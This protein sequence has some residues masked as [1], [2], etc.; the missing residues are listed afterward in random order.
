[1]GDGGTKVNEAKID[2][3][4]IKEEWLLGNAVLAFFGALLMAQAWQPSDIPNEILNLV[5]PTLPQLVVLAMVAVL[6][7][8][9]IIFALGSAI[10][11]IRSW[12]ITQATS[13]SHFL[14]WL[15]WFVFLISLLS[16]LSEIATDQW[17]AEVLELGGVAFLLFLAFR[18]IVRPLINPAKWLVHLLFKVLRWAWERIVALRRKPDG[19]GDI[20]DGT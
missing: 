16:G 20:D 12:A 19:E 5:V 10:P 6:A 2:V 18:K 17:W 8:L 13:Y 14:D 9:S 3:E 1:M 7:T 11:R 15:M 4:R